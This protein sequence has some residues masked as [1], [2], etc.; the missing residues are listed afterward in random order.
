[1]QNAE[2]LQKELSELKNKME[3]ACSITKIGFWDYYPKSKKFVL[4]N[5]AQKITGFENNTNLTLSSFAHKLLNNKIASKII[6]E[7]KKSIQEKKDINIELSFT[8]PK[9]FKETNIVII[10]KN[11][12]YQN[13]TNKITGIIQDIT[14]QKLS[15]KQLKTAKNKAEESDVL[16][17]AFLANMSHEIRTPLNAILGFARLLTDKNTD[18]K[19]RQEYS[20]YITS[21]AENLLHLIQDIIDVSK[22]EAG[23]IKIEKNVC[24][25]N[26]TL[27]EIKVTF[28]KE[29]LAKNKEHIQL[30]LK[31]FNTDENFAIQTDTFRFHQIFNNLIS[32]ALK[33]I[34]KGYIE[35]GYIIP[36]KDYIQFYVKDT[37]IGI[38]LNKRELVFSRFG[39]IKNKK[40][41]NPGGTGL[42]LSITKQLVEKLGGKIWY[43]S[44]L[45]KGTIFSFTL[46]FKEIKNANYKPIN[47]FNNFTQNFDNEI[48]I[49]A[50]EDDI[51]NMILLKDLLAA[52]TDKIKLEEAVNGRDA[53]QKLK[54]KNYDLI[55]MD[56][57]MPEMDGYE[58]TRYIREKLPAPLNKIPILG[59]SANAVKEEI[60]K[61]INA[62]MNSMLSK[63]INPNEL[64]KQ[65]NNLTKIISEK[66]K[67]EIIKDYQVPKT[68]TVI[69]VNFLKKLFKND[70]T[71]LNKTFN[72]YLK[73][74]PIQLKTLKSSIN[75][76]D[77]EN[78]KITAHSMKSTFKYIGRDDLSN[79][80]L[81]IENISTHDL[82]NKEK[83]DR[84]IEFLFTEW[85]L[86]ENELKKLT[87]N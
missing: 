26:K 9:N 61:G 36:T 66:E 15:E 44:E 20:E 4:S 28:E 24:F 78:L 14:K 21:S 17:S 54:E 58:T 48:K 41:K 59:L 3:L 19:Q 38:P 18:D 65:I 83:I 46:P 34:N 70:K 11:I 87:I 68:N 40:I 84:K 7:I 29:K 51:L 57:R 43:E 56:V 77:Y 64:M 75:N 74:I 6:L 71:K 39:Q 79:I 2:N 37:G 60:E 10:T 85:Y 8:H 12:D 73:E 23:K 31:T 35:F 49:L 86:I 53:L 62:G 72:A 47:K 67:F 27:H 32:N 76:K 81:E 52:N 1:M 25:I 82:K 80:F 22:I 30:I 42:G 5:L 55:I 50:V 33:F 45:N 63:P 16:K 13:N 69:N